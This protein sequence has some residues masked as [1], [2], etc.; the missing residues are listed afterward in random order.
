MRNGD[1]FGSAVTLSSD[2]NTLAVGAPGED[3]QAIGLDGDQLDN[4][5][6]GAGAVYA[7]TRNVDTWSQRAYVKASNTGTLDQFGNAVALSGDGQ[8][9]VIGA[10]GEDSVATGINGDQADDL[11]T[12]A[13]AV[14]IFTSAA[15]LWSQQAYIKASNTGSEDWF[16]ERV[17][18]SSDGNTL[19]ITARNEDSGTFGI[20][21]IRRTNP[22]PIRVVYTCSRA[23][24]LSGL[25]RRTSKL[26]VPMQQTNLARPS[27]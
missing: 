25:S 27:L 26:P 14:Y 16:G 8:T 3:S 12:N 9:L 13:G 20:N 5:A 1:L 10:H 18:F 22:Q 15:G 23:A 11:A 21:G 2:G 24:P 17:A 4:S 6:N 19:A 7:F